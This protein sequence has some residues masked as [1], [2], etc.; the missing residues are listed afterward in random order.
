MRFA[1]FMWITSHLGEYGFSRGP[2]HGAVG[3]L[4]VLLTALLL[5]CALRRH[6]PA[7]LAVAGLVCAVG[8]GWPA[9]H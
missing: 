7:D 5:G 2:L 9:L 8:I 4:A 3:T 1:W 6:R